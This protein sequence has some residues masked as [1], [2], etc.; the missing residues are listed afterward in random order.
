MYGHPEYSEITVVTVIFIHC[1]CWG[2]WDFSFPCFR[3]FY[4]NHFWSLYWTCYSTASVS[5]FGFLA[6]KHAGL[7]PL[8]RD[9]TC[10]PCNGR[11]CFNHWTAR[12]VTGKV[13]FQ[14]ACTELTDWCHDWLLSLLFNSQ[15][16]DCNISSSISLRAYLS[17]PQLLWLL[18]TAGLSTNAHGMQ[19]RPA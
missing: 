9:W 17:E 19:L 14:R 13:I 5:F 10:T 11:W 2:K 15:V 3:D 1:V 4:V 16:S 12:E 6:E 7:S 18:E 8:T